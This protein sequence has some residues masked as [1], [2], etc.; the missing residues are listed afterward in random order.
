VLVRAGTAEVVERDV[1]IEGQTPMTMPI[2]DTDR[3]PLLDGCGEY[4]EALA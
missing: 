1:S 3:R 2:N 4:P